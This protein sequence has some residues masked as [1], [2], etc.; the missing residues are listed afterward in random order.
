[1]KKLT[2]QNARVDLK[3][4]HKLLN[5]LPNLEALELER[6]EDTSTSDKKI[7]LDLKS[8]KIER[9]KMTEC[10][11]LAS[12]LEFLDKCAIKELELHNSFQ[13]AIESEVI[14]K[15]LK[16]QEKSL[17]KLIGFNC[18]LEFLVDLK[19]LRLECLEY[20][21]DADVV[22]LEFLRHQTDLKSLG[23][24]LSDYH[25]DMFDQILEV[26]DLESLDLWGWTNDSSG[27]DSLH[28]LQKLKRLK[29]NQHLC[30]NILDHLK[31]GV[32]SNLE[33]LDAYFEDASLDSIQEMNRFTPNL[34]KIVICSTSSDT[35]YALL[36]TLDSLEALKIERG[37]EWEIT[38]IVY[39]KIKYLGIVG[40]DHNVEQFTK[41]FP[42][43]EFFAVHPKSLRSN[44]IIFCRIVEWIEAV[45]DT[46]YGNL[47][48]HRIRFRI[49]FAVLPGTWKTV[50]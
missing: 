11:G 25:D 50:G 2:I 47:E 13:R 3:I 24:D 48:L 18:D 19:D 42:N 37:R 4:V 12:L 9:I 36:E 21:N 27:L 46:L 16:S 14:Q 43:L 29:V 35:I 38:E 30:A 5:L 10:T 8:T 40:F 28:K 49:G 45:K 23:L 41:Q 17:K 34:K 1:V 26:K 7:K 39:P 33:E 6:I 31:F 32:F 20:R 22:S 44:G 15:L